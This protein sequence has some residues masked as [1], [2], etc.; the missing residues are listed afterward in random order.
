MRH[1]GLDTADEYLAHTAIALAAAALHDAHVS[2]LLSPPSSPL[3]RP[4]LA[5]VRSMF[6][7]AEMKTV[8]MTRGTPA[9]TD[10]AAAAATMRRLD[11]A[12]APA[13][14]HTHAHAFARTDTTHARLRARAR[15]PLARSLTHSPARA[16]TAH[17]RALSTRLRGNVNDVQSGHA[18]V[19]Y[20]PSAPDESPMPVLT[21]A[22]VHSDDHLEGATANERHEPVHAEPRNRYRQTA[23]HR[24]RETF[25]GSMRTSTRLFDTTPHHPCCTKR[26]QPLPRHSAR[27]D[28]LC[29]LGA[30]TFRVLAM[31][32]RSGAPS[33]LIGAI[34]EWSFVLFWI[35]KFRF[36]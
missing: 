19:H 1:A 13:R 24:R 30:T 7:R 26:T 28:H 33:S 35:R 21:D 12:S 11:R 32:A 36:F 9:V 31:P 5:G 29:A 25:H 2:S 6:R 14:V 8:R 16:H 3:A 18:V 20:L 23:V 17:P 15:A 34:F 22:D 10:A 4:P 27:H